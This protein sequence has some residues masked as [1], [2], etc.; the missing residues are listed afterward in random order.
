MQGREA[1][2]GIE[3]IE[4]GGGAGGAVGGGA[5][6]LYVVKRGKLLPLPPLQCPRVVTPAGRSATNDTAD[7]HAD[8]R[9][10]RAPLNGPSDAG[11]QAQLDVEISVSR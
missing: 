1:G 7:A 5:E 8:A 6:S 10:V 2:P 11:N 3:L 4:A 9:M